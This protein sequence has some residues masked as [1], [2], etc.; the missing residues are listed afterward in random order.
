[1]T[2]TKEGGVS[3][4]DWRRELKH[5]QKKGA[6]RKRRGGVWKRQ[7]VRKG[8]CDSCLDSGAL[9]ECVRKSEWSEV[10]VC[11]DA[12]RVA[13]VRRTRRANPRRQGRVAIES[14]C[15]CR[16]EH[17]PTGHQRP[18]VATELKGSRDSLFLSW[19]ILGIVCVWCGG[20]VR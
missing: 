3:A 14:V 16:G 5:A 10:N 18:A 1:M 17:V 7:R 13:S 19:F 2:V 9:L 15:V 8:V 4:P 11:A 12:L 6:E 20:L